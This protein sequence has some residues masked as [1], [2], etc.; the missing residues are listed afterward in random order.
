MVVVIICIK[1]PEPPAARVAL[2]PRRG[3]RSGR[4]RGALS[5]DERH[6]EAASHRT[7][8]PVLGLPG[9]GCSDT[10][11]KVGSTAGPASPT[12]LS[13]GARDETRPD[14]SSTAFLPTP[15]PDI[16]RVDSADRLS[17]LRRLQRAGVWRIR[18][19]GI[20]VSCVLI[21][22]AEVSFRL[23]F[24]H[25][26]AAPDNT[27]THTHTHAHTNTHTHIRPI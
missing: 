12:V 3:G 18:V 24:F 11:H 23:R 22:D 16:R 1:T 25:R 10:A 7:W 21:T 20:D 19:A 13:R 8:P 17:Y 9:L 14:S 5:R 15:S 26:L 27:H 2:Y 4:A 6:I